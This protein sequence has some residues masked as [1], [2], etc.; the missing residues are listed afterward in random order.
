[1]DEE[2]K[3]LR[4]VLRADVFDRLTEF[5]KQFR[6]GMQK[7]DYGVAIQILLDFYEHTNSVSDINQKLDFLLSSINEPKE[8][9]HED[10]ESGIT[11]LGGEKLK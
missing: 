11:M 2:G 4:T 8:E 7:W 3:F 5:A 6:N 9:V 10:K 1:M